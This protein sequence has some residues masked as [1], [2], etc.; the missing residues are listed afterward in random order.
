MKKI[1]ILEFQENYIKL[2]AKDWML[3]SSGTADSFNTMTA[4]W[5]GIGYMWNKAVA[6]TVVRP[7]RY[8]YEFVEQNDCFTLSFFAPEYRK[9]LSLLGTKSGRD[10]DKIA[11]SG[12][13]PIFTEELSLTTFSQARIMIECRKLYSEDMK[14][15]NFIDTQCLE[16]WYGGA[17]GGLHRMYISEILNVWVENK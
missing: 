2:L 17:Y 10:G 7:E 12:L 3:I 4:S 8:T 16:K 5:G 6:F 9:A 1:D 13:T 11:A 14:A 15:E